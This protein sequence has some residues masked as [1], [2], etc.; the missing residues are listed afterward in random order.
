M[1][2]LNRERE[3]KTLQIDPIRRGTNSQES[4]SI[5]P[6]RHHFP[7]IAYCP[8][9]R[10][11]I[12]QQLRQLLYYLRFSQTDSR[13]PFAIFAL[14]VLATIVQIAAFLSILAGR[15]SIR[16]CSGWRGRN[17]ARSSSSY[18]RSWANRSHCGTACGL[19]SRASRW[20]SAASGGRRL[21]GGANLRS[22]RSWL[23]SGTGSWC[24]TSA[25][26][27]SSSCSWIID[28]CRRRDCWDGC[29][30]GNC[31]CNCLDLKRASHC[32]KASC[33]HR[34]GHSGSCSLGHG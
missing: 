9:K 3:K 14:I 8:Y 10:K 5:E 30:L 33:S 28:L 13:A 31:L 17:R 16:R 27:S 32:W 26:W 23:T 7:H 15:W 19:T 2:D 22:G 29:W 6:A 24:A 21:A 1:E 18:F 20:R 34:G 11:V 12:L 25:N 4:E